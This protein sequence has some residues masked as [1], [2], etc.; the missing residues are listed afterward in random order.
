[1]AREIAKTTGGYASPFER[2]KR[3]NEAGNEYWE[4]RDLAEVLEY[5]QYRNFEAVIE[6][7]KLACFN[8]GHRIEDHFADVSKMIEIGKGG[9]REIK[10][11]LLSRYACYLAIQNADPKKE[12]VAHGQTYF[13][14]QTRRQELADKSIEEERRVLLREEIRRHN[15]QLAD[16]AKGAGVIEPIDYAIFQN[17]GYMGLYGGLKQE[18]LH[19]RKGLKKSQ[20]ILDHMGSTELA[21]NLF[22][23]TQAEEKLRRDAVKGKD[24]ANRTHREVGAKVRQTIRELGGT[25]PEELPVAESIKKI[26]AKQRKQLGKAETPAKKKSE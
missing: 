13:A 4:S 21:A 16:A 10:V 26:E 2:I 12:I 8:S 18:D 23:T 9:R 14:I 22:R 3:T 11:A 24:A 7:A 15:V 20:K 19:R 5:T 6:K 1:M 25:M 17:H